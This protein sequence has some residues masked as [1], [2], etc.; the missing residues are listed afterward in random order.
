M[1][2]L[3]LT[4]DTRR[5]YRVLKAYAERVGLPWDV[6]SMRRSCSEQ[7][8]LYSIGR[9]TPG[10]VV[11]HAQGCRSWHVLGRAFDITLPGAPREDYAFLGRAWEN[12]GGVWGGSFSNFDDIGHFEWHPGQTVEQVCPNPAACEQVVIAQLQGGRAPW[13]PMI[14]VAGAAAVGMIWWH[15]R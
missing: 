8:A 2:E 10:R 4:P 7:R 12:M 9:D 6:R 5:A 11:T 1:N 3:E 14:A 15:G 13:G